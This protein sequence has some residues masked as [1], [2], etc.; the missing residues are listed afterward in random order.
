MP[1]EMELI[2]I[3]LHKLKFTQ[4]EALEY[5]H[6]H[7]MQQVCDAL[8]W[9]EEQYNAFLYDTGTR[10]LSYYINDVAAIAEIERN[11]MFWAWWKLHWISRE[12]IFCMSIEAIKKLHLNKRVEIY[13]SLHDAKCLAEE[14]YPDGKLL[15]CSYSKMIG[16]IITNETAK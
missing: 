16:D 3:H 1:T 9:N 14:I 15:G 8:Q 4:E 5:K 7:L 6:L 13:T 2:N 10:Y 11:R 12:E